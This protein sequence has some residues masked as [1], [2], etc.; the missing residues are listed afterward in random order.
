MSISPTRYCSISLWTNAYPPRLLFRRIVLNEY[1]GIYKQ[2]VLC[3]VR[4]FP[5]KAI[6]LILSPIKHRVS[7]KDQAFV[8]QY[9][10]GNRVTL[11]YSW[12]INC[13]KPILS[14]AR[15]RQTIGLFS[16]LLVEQQALPAWCVF[17]P[18]TLYTTTVWLAS[19]YIMNHIESKINKAYTIRQ[20]YFELNN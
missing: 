13:Q 2:R 5:T 6:H 12:V 19:I 17:R 11:L 4:E 8:L 20:S 3:L 18:I 16:L 14:Y 7:C 15:F 1:K 10:C 9:T